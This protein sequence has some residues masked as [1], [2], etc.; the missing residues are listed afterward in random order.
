MTV[1]GQR[2]YVAAEDQG[3]IFFWIQADHSEL[4]CA[5]L[6][7][8]KIVLSNAKDLPSFIWKHANPP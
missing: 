6:L 5:S 7:L 1:S 2:T 4:L 3:K 8:N